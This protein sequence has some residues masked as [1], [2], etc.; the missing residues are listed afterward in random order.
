MG[1][2]VKTAEKLTD[3]FRPYATFKAKH[4]YGGHDQADEPGATCLCFPKRRL[5][6]TVSALDGLEVTM[7]TAFGKA[8]LFGKAPHTL[9]SVVT[10]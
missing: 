1:I 6:V 5:R 3:R 4:K 8:A 7:H 9:L 2:E 10:N